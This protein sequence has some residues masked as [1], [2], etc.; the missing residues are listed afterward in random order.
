MMWNVEVD[1]DKCTGA[2]LCVDN[3]PTGVYE[4]VD[5]KAVPVHAEECIGCETC[6]E[7][8]PTGACL[9]TEV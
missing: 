3:C 5:N 8:C 9:V 6:M 2:G 4:M 1:A 7:V